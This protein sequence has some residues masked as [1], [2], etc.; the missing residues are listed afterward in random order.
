MKVI[1]TLSILPLQ[2]R[3]QNSTSQQLWQLEG[4]SVIQNLLVTY[5]EL[6]FHSEKKKNNNSSV[7]LQLTHQKAGDRSD[8]L[9]KAAIVNILTA[10]PEHHCEGEVC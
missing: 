6:V 7:S 5:T 9:C 8:K 10:H 4:R 3:Y 2:G 1:P